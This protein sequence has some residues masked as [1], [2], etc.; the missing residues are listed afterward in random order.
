M[1]IPSIR[2][3]ALLG[4]ILIG[5]FVRLH[6]I[7]N[8]PLDWHAFRQADTASVTREYTKNGINILLPK[9]HDL[10]N[11]ASGTDNPEGYRMVEFPLINAVIASIVLAIPALPLELAHRLLSVFLSLGSIALL[12]HFTKAISGYRVAIFTAALFAL[13]PF[14][15]YYSRVI[16]PEPALVF[17][18]L[19]GLWSFEK[20]LSTQ[21][22]NWYLLSVVSIALALL[23]KPFIAFFAPVFLA[24]VYTR[25]KRT[26]LNGALLGVYA[27]VVAA[28][29]AWWRFWISQFPEGI[30]ASDWLF[31][32]DGIRFRPAWFRWLGYERLIVLML[33]Y[34]GSIFVMVSWFKMNKEEWL[35]YGTWIIGSLAYL[36]IIATGNVRHDYYQVILIPI[37]CIIVARGIIVLQQLLG[38][39]VLPVVASSIIGLLLITALILSWQQVSGFFTINNWEYIE[40]GKAVRRL[41]PEDALVIAPAFGDTLFLYQTHRRGWPIGYHI[42]EKI[43][44]GATHYVSTS[45]DDEARELEEQYFTLEKTPTY[46]LIDLTRSHDS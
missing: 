2:L 34:V 38:R 44:Q 1:N 19:L 30:P 45:Y 14:N 25:M 33:G 46:I 15:I 26:L 7:T 41:T 16:L 4:I 18:F 39:F 29:F 37:I 21:K 11:I 22:L 32:S 40:A 27:G 35:V 36:A 6:A 17:S 12:F 13:L 43:D 24:L 10:S 8:Q 9:Y 23:L 3:S 5:F 31:N 42:E 28:P 20:W